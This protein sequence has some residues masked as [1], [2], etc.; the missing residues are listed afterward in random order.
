MVR[1]YAVALEQLT[2][3][4]IP[5]KRRDGRQFSGEHFRII[6]AAKSLIDS[7]KGLTVDLS[8][9]MVLAPAEIALKPP[10]A[11]L[12][13]DSTQITAE[14]ILEGLRELKAIRLQLV[15]L[16]EQVGNQLPPAQPTPPPPNFENNPPE[17]KL[18][19]I[20]R[21]AIRVDT[22]FKRWF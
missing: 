12:T 4:E 18:P 20:V 8:L 17:E 14:T 6:S 9:K 7:N 13:L 11:G 1:K 16:R 5:I 10:T 21:A 22:W 3:E 15:L 2:G 19:I